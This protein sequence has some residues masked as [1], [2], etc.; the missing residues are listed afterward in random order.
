MS[1][2]LR[3]GIFGILGVAGLMYAYNAS[4]RM[5]EKQLRNRDRPECRAASRFEAAPEAR[6]GDPLQ[7]RVDGRRT[8]RRNWWWRSARSRRAVTACRS[9]GCCVSRRSRFRTLSVANDSRSGDNWFEW[10][11]AEPSP[12]ALR[13]RR[14][15]D[16]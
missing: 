6:A 1:V 3:W 2:F 4:K 5:A 10:V 9:I 11:G 14:M 13:M 8:A 7:R 12:E 16:C 15:R